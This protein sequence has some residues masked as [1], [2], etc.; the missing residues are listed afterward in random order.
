MADPQRFIASEGLRVL[1]FGDDAVVFEPLSWD[2]HLLN[3]AA[4]AVLDLLLQA[5]QSTADIEAFLREALLPQAQ[6]DAGGHAE[7]LLAELHGLG[8]A[9]PADGGR[10]ALR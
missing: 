2:A 9:R 10:G 4:R 8:L 3:P 1:D 6:P 5:P 7:R